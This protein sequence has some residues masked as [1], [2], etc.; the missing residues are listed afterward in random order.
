MKYRIGDLV[1]SSLF[2]GEATIIRTQ[3]SSYSERYCYTI[4]FR[5]GLIVDVWEESIELVAPPAAG[6]MELFT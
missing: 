3:Y 2:K 1:T 6:Y 5:R 4:V